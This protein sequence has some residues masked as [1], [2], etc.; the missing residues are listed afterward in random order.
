MALV[1]NEEQNLL[2]DSAREFFRSQAPVTAFREIR[3]NKDPAGLSRDLWSQMVEL[4][5]AGII[6]PEEHGGLDFGYQGLGVVMEEAGRTLA[7]SP[8]MST[9]VLSGSAVMI[10]GSEEQKSDTL[11][12]IAAGD[13]ILAFALEERNHHAPNEITTKAGKDGDGYV[14]T[15]SKKFVLDGHIADQIIVTAC[16]AEGPTLFLV[17]SDAEG[18]TCKRTAMAD[19]RN[20][21]NLTLDKVRV[22]ASAVL[23]A[24]GK[25]APVI[26]QVLDRARVCI[27]AEMLGS[28]QELFE[29]TVE[30]LKERQQ[31]GVPI[32]SFQGLK[33]RA[34]KMFC[35]LEVSKSVLMAA[36][37]AL[38]N[39]DADLPALA[40]AAKAKLCETFEL[41]SSEAIQMHGGIGMTDEADFGFFLKR[42]RVA[43]QTFGDAAFHRN[44]YADLKGF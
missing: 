28:S 4:G 22:D 17:D 15:G 44:R 26:D 20:A 42:S 2:K 7:L 37:T 9:V 12:G 27:A 18:L 16:T 23:G 24:V 14:L 32:G 6:F 3:D 40:S 8:L 41:T 5:W 36:I 25:A 31:F 38:D 35:E 11:A 19:S 10:A 29:R 34:A 30:Y 1:L 43:S 21:A 13:R 33:H 39:G